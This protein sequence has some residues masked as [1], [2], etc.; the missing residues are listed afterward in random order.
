MNEH[1]DPSREVEVGEVGTGFT[2]RKAA[3]LGK[4]E[5]SDRV[6]ARIHQLPD[7]THPD[8][9]GIKVWLA[10][11]QDAIE[12]DSVL[13]TTQKTA[14]LEQVEVLAKLG[15]NPQ[16]SE[17]EKSGSGAIKILQGMASTLSKTATL[18]KACEQL[19][20][21]ITEAMGLAMPEIPDR[22]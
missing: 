17:L 9:A 14:G 18:P 13:S 7:S 1:R 21:L 12:S 20:P 5:I 2:G 3:N 8:Q 19:L 15:Q 6:A 10:Q 4:V 11:L 22:A 16:R